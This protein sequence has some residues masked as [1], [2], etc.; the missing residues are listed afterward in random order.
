[1]KLGFTLEA[2]TGRVLETSQPD[3]LLLALTTSLTTTMRDYH[4]Q[5]MEVPMDALMLYPTLFDD[6][7]L[8]RMRQ[9]ADTYSFEFTVHLPYMWLDLSSLNEDIRQASLRSVLHG[10]EKGRRLRPLGY[11]LHL[12][13]EWAAGFG[14]Y[15]RDGERKWL[16]PERVVEQARKS[17]AEV[18][19]QVEPA[20]ICVENLGGFPFSNLLPLIRESGA[21]VC[22]DV[23][24][25]VLQNGD[26]LSALT[27]FGDLVR[28]IH[29]HDVVWMKTRGGGIVL[30]DHQPL[31]GG[32][33]PVPELVKALVDREY[34]GTIILEVMR[35]EHLVSSVE[36]LRRLLPPL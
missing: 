28:V 33:V 10:L 18:V 1:M 30:K 11:I 34:Q 8:S 12:T 29:L 7:A 19:H 17:L 6:N 35:R 4:L 20:T 13:A 32:I 26:P 5:A 15:E 16:F 2:V 22:L 24:H 9:L 21:S 23:G 36:M 25:L 31:G 14:T 3:S 27:E